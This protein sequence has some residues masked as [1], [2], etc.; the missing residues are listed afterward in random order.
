MNSGTVDSVFCSRESIENGCTTIK[1]SIKDSHLKQQIIASQRYGDGLQEWF[2]L[3]IIARGNV[4]G[5]FA[6]HIVHFR[7]IFRCHQVE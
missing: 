6:Y 7:V 3:V 5:Y 2:S 1:P 4:G